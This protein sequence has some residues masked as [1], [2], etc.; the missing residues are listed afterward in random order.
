[1]LDKTM[2]IKKSFFGWLAIVLISLI[3]VF[4]W[5]NFGAGA[6]E[7]S[8][9]GDVVH[10]LGE[11]LGLVGMT[12][13]ALT[14]ILSTRIKAIEDIFGGLD[15]VY[16]VHGILGGVALIFI[17]FH[18]IF[19]VLKF[20]PQNISQAAAYLL[21]ST[22]WSINF[23]I[24][25]LL[26]LI[27]LIYI[28]LFTKMKYHRW[29]FTHEFLGLMFLFAV[30]HIFLV[31][32]SV[33]AD[34]IFTGYFTYATLVSL[35]GISAFSYSLFLKNRL[36]KNAV[37]KISKIDSHENTFVLEL[38]PEHKPL[39]Y[40]SGQF[41]FIR[42]Y[43]KKLSKEEHPFS[44]ASTSGSD[45]IRIVIKKLGDFTDKLGHLN[46][47]DKV[48]LEG[49]Y[50]RFHFRNYGKKNQV[51]IAGGIGITPFIGMAEDLLEGKG[52]DVKVDLYYSVSK[53]EDFIGYE[54]LGGISKK[55]ERFRFF[56]WNTSQKG[57]INENELKKS[58]L[59]NSEVFI[60]GP[61]KFKESLIRKLIKL[62]V[63]KRDIHEEV[64]DFR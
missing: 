3:P 50:G 11:I 20:I 44:I 38:E 37:Y 51:W 7:F 26:G 57:Y 15:K 62:G 64:F 32:G 47:G 39:S 17:L 63:R 23:G 10:S 34:N 49:P 43:N 42:F 28:T 56:P 24:L 2:K 16:I 59:K 13:F 48:S 40:K 25:S 61:S 33:S 46:T 60:C 1:M 6:I 54:F 14:F 21:P 9:Y 27:I 35:I 22:Y 45:K 36:M 12:I 41:V 8:N 52:K 53:K 55:I 58:D 18:P 19:L 5:F 31:R 29:K 30:L 4:L